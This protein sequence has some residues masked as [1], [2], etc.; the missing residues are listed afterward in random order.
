MK[1]VYNPTQ[2]GLQLT[3]AEMKMFAKANG[4][5]LRERG[6]AHLP[7]DSSNTWFNEM[8]WSDFR[9]HPMLIKL[10][11][12]NALTNK[13]LRITELP[14]DA[15]FEINTDWQNYE[16][17]ITFSK[18]EWSELVELSIEEDFMERSFFEDE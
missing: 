14:D 12:D 8:V 3:E 1:I 18:E 9:T 6:E 10:V 17:I 16:R 2:F 7:L 13:N 4:W 11:E 15:I 5:T